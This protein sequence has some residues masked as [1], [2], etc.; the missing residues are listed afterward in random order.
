[1]DSENRTR[2]RI[3][4]T[5]QNMLGTPPRGADQLTADDTLGRIL[6]A[7]QPWAS[8]FA[9]TWSIIATVLL[10]LRLWQ[11]HRMAG[12]MD[13]MNA[14]INANDPIFILRCLGGAAVLAFAWDA[15]R[16]VLLQAF[17][18]PRG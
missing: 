12:P 16:Y 3:E 13:A 9:R 11:I 5:I 7:A 4:E 1:M 17:R 2:Q 8:H 14:W 10:V 6:R 15:A 18:R